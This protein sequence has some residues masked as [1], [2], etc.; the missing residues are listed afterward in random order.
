MRYG[1]N[2]QVAQIRIVRTMSSN[3]NL[4]TAGNIPY[5][6]WSDLSPAGRDS[7]ETMTSA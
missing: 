1:A 4:F 5:G 3:R 6:A 2:L 7:H